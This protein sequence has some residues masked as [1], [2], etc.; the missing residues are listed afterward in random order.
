M[1]MST[2]FEYVNIYFEDDCW[3][4]YNTKHILYCIAVAAASRKC[5]GSTTTTAAMPVAD[6]QHFHE[7]Y[8]M[9][10]HRTAYP[11][12][13]RHAWAHTTIFFAFF[14]PFHDDD[15]EK[16]NYEWDQIYYAHLYGSPIVACGGRTHSNTHTLADMMEWLKNNN[17]EIKKK[18][19]VNRKARRWCETPAHTSD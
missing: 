15:K 17:E 10:T 3:G 7:M 19:Y 18:R 5:C 13:P 16:E 1:D 8:H 14:S 9:C 4:D 6:T 2:C 12:H 11:S